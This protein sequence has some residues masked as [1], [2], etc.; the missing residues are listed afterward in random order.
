MTAAVIG[1]LLAAPVPASEQSDFFESNVRPVLA[2]NCFACHQATKMGGLEMSSR[3]ALLKGGTRGPAIIPGNAK[4]SLLI[5]AVGYQHNDQRLRMPPTAKLADD[6]IGDLATWIDQGAVWPGPDMAKSDPAADAKKIT[7]EQRSFWSFQPVRKPAPPAVRNEAWPRAA[8]DRFILAKLEENGLKPSQ[9]ANRRKLIRRAYF[10]LIGLP[11][12]PEEVDAFVSDPDPKAFEHVVERLLASPRYGE[13]WGRFWLDVARYSDDKLNSTQMEPYP[14][15]YRYRDWVIQAFN[16]DL[17]YDLFIKAQLAGDQLEHTASKDLV[18][19]L[20]FYGLSPQFQDDRIDATAR[21]FLGLTV[22]CAQC[23]DHK[24]DPIPTEDYYSL[25]GVF[26]STKIDEYP[27]ASEDVVQ[28]YKAREKTLNEEKAALDEFLNTQSLQVVDALAAQSADYL[29]AAWRVLGPEKQSSRKAAKDTELDLETL[30]G[31]VRYLGSNPREHPLFDE[32]DRLVA[33][34]ANEE[35]VSEF[36]AKTQDLIISV[37]REKKKVDEE[38]K[39]RLGG[40]DSARK[41]SQTVLLSLERDRHF[42]WRNVASAQSFSMPAEFKTGILH[43]KDT[44]VERFLSPTLKRYTSEQRARIAALEKA[45]PEKYPFLHVI[46]DVEKPENEHVHIR[47]SKDNLGDEVPRHFLS[48]LSTGEPKPFSQGSGRLELAEAIADP[49]NPL[50]ARVMANRIWLNHFGQGIVGTPSNFG[51]MGERPSHPELL[52]YLAARF[53]ESGWSVKAMHREIM[54]SETY[55]MDTGR[56]ARAQEI[57][58]E[59]RLLWRANYRRLDVEE[60]RDSVLYVTGSLDAKTGGP[61]IELTESENNRRTVYAYVSRRRL[62]TTLGIFDFPNPNAHSERRIETNT[63]LQG[64]FMLNNEFMMRQA[65][66]LAA[67]LETTAKADEARITEAY[68]RL[69]GREPSANELALGREY[70]AGN[71]D[72]LARY[73]QTLLSSNEFL[74][75]N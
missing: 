27:L 3:E 25:L 39:I 49:E 38:N 60:L 40:D 58:P 72:G 45:L 48:V 61:P 6:Q 14:N 75:V 7:A 51:Q 57:D 8:V 24:F 9:P 31:W 47:G 71:P 10:D 23:H 21:G 53:V 64:L 5:Q 13:R 46:A 4:D 73:A 70:L 59:N 68:R 32:W 1:T 34:S 22:A 28:D 67:K 66:T 26:S 50:T 56:D 62:D 15:A 33:D 16:Q 54:L 20:A 43:Y 2:N 44:A 19:G 55:A 36:A 63:P 29:M 69:F 30:D 74:Y 37:I 18:A 65:E 12:T 42:L 35:K 41:A 17:P 52:D 11:P